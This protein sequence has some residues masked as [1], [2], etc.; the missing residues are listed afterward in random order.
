VHESGVFPCR[1]HSTMVLHAYILLVIPLVAAVH[2]CGLSQA[3][4][5]II[6]NSVRAPNICRVHK[7]VSSDVWREFTGCYLRRAP[8]GEET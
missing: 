4:Y 8:E 1:Y 6:V 3:I 7:V 2:G 5:M